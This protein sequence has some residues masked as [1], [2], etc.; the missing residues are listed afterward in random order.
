MQFEHTQGGRKESWR[1]RKRCGRGVRNGGPAANLDCGVE[2]SLRALYRHHTDL[3]ESGIWAARFSE[4]PTRALT[5][6]S[7]AVVAHEETGSGTV[8]V[9]WQLE[10]K[11]Q[12]S[13]AVALKPPPP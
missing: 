7:W 4:I 2:S 1:E 6:D 12:A 13:V 3:K 9:G 10:V 5:R 11:I 8:G